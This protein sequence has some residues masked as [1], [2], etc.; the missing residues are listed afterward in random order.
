MVFEPKYLGP[1]TAKFYWRLW[2]TKNHIARRV[3]TYEFIDEKRT[4]RSVTIDVD[5]GELSQALPP[6]MDAGCLPVPVVTLHKRPLFDVDL[7]GAN[8]Q[9]IHLCRRYE[10]M[11]VSAHILVGLCLHMGYD[12]DAAKQR[13][14]FRS[15]LIFLG[16]NRGTSTAE[17]DLAEQYF[18]DNAK[19]R[20]PFEYPISG[21]QYHTERLRD[22]YIQCVDYELTSNGNISIVKFQFTDVLGSKKPAVISAGTT[23]LSDLTVDSDA[24]DVDSADAARRPPRWLDRIAR[25]FQPVAKRW[26]TTRPKFL[27]KSGITAT[28]FIVPI[29][30][31][32]PNHLRLVAGKGLSI[33]DVRVMANENKTVLTGFNDGLSTDRHREKASLLLRDLPSRRYN[34]LVKINT[35]P[36]VFLYPALAVSVLQ[37]TIMMIALQAGPQVV[38]RNPSAFTG[39]TL[40]APFITVL[41]L[42][43][44]SEHSL[45]TAIL[46]WPRIFLLSSSI[47]TVISGVLISILPPAAQHN[48]GE[49]EGVDVPVF[50][51]LMAT[52]TLAIICI[53]LILLIL[54]RMR[55]MLKI[56]DERERNVAQSKLDGK[57]NCD[58]ETTDKEHREKAMRR[59]VM[60]FRLVGIVFI[61]VSG[62]LWHHFYSIWMG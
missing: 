62:I 26:K 35:V 20:L 56:T 25:R 60:F 28:K 21:I 51:A 58:I 27:E 23:N 61:L 48:N 33:D 4:R 38:S 16:Y 53:T 32:L 18:I 50:W 49:H 31:D 45:V 11:A 46:T 7:R 41:F 3:D 24:A 59:V 40:I 12:G 55:I 19:E 39:T 34:V 37:F 57:A 2:Q 30:F 1:E 47:M 17:K 42:A 43:R 8:G 10:N 54:W 14:L 29:G 13:N 15:A 9:P 52:V 22:R 36:D 44:S 5:N 6:N